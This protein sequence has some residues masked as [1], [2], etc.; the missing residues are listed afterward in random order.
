MIIPFCKILYRYSKGKILWHLFHRTISRP[1]MSFAETIIIEEVLNNLKPMRCLEWGAGYS[2]LIFPRF[3]G[4]NTRWIALE[5]NPDWALKIK[6]LN[7]NPNVTIS[8]IAPNKFPWSDENNDGG[9]LDLKDYIDFPDQFA[10][11]NF[12]LV[13]GRARKDCLIKAYDLCKED[14][15]VVLHD[16]ERQYYQQPLRLYQYQFS[17]SEHT[18]GQIKLWMGSKSINIS[19]RFRV[20]RYTK[21][22]QLLRF[23]GKIRSK[24]FK[25]LKVV[26][27]RFLVSSVMH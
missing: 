18:Q 10:P 15:I 13:D 22:A 24:L 5:H 23:F 27:S 14:G 7:K 25:Q 4:Q 19:K 3:A 17:F 8:Y 11:F 20:N 26:N 21:L 9:L 12:I 6:V 1:M 2:T 16:A